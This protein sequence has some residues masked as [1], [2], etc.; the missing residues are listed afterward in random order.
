[1]LGIAREDS[2]NLTVASSNSPRLPDLLFTNRSTQALCIAAP[3]AAPSAV[4]RQTTG[5]RKI[6]AQIWR[7]TELLLPPPVSR[8]S[9]GLM[10]RERKRLRPYANPRVAPSITALATLAGVIFVVVKP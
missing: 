10:P 5:T 8:I 7:Q 9:A 3:R 2:S 4:A 6:S 1:M